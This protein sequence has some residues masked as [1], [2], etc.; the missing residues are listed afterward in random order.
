MALEHLNLH[1]VRTKNVPIFCPKGDC[2][3]V[4]I[5][6]IRQGGV[7]GAAALVKLQPD[8]KFCPLSSNHVT[9]CA[10]GEVHRRGRLRCAGAHRSAPLLC[11]ILLVLFLA[12]QEK[13]VTPPTGILLP[14]K[15]PQPLWIVETKTVDKFQQEFLSTQ[16]V[17][18][19]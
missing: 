3:I 14:E 6:L 1:P 11:R 16:P 8:N 7:C 18:S 10:P 17:E 4:L 15:I 12:E 2:C 9:K 5:L 13:Y 19:C